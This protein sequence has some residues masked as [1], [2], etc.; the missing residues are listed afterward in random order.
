MY[1]NTYTDL[2]I[3]VYIYMLACASNGHLIKCF[4]CHIKYHAECQE[5]HLLN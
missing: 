2:Y 1:S 3:Y 5:F 4:T